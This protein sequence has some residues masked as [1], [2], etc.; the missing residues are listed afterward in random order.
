[1]ECDQAAS[2]GLSGRTATGASGGGRAAGATRNLADFNIEAIT[3]GQARLVLAG[4]GQTGPFARTYENIVNAA[5]ALMLD[6]AR[7][8]PDLTQPQV[9]GN[10][11][12]YICADYALLVARG[13][14]SAKYEPPGI[15]D[16][17]L[18]CTGIGQLP[19]RNTEPDDLNSMAAWPELMPATAVGTGVNANVQ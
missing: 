10:T 7:R 6:F 1:L 17:L 13:P 11:F 3:P 15:S 8:A 2:A 18:L 14:N 4:T 16:A 12:T 19:M 5:V 9:T